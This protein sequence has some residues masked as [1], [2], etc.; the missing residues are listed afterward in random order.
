M[1]K[2]ILLIAFRNLRKHTFYSTINIAGLAIGV[3]ACLLIT[4]FIIDELSYDKYN[5]K[6]DRIYRINNEIKFG[7]NHMQL[8]TSAAPT[9]HTLIQDYPEVEAAVRFRSYGSYLVKAENSTEN[10]KENNVIWTDSTFFKIFSVKVLEGNPNT[11]LKEPA[12]IAISKRTAEKHFPNESALGKTMILDNKYNAKVTAVYENIPSTSHFHFDI[13]IAMVGDWPVAREAQSSAYLSNNFN[14]YLLLK[15][16]A[17]A[18]AFERKL[19]EFLIKY[20][21]PQIAQVLGD[22]FTL[23]KFRE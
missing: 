6:A 17:D 5:E 20:I 11:A 7:G 10:I 22:E 23:E 21:G 4:L 3:S 19:P 16:G 18:K 12:S 13:L 2:S 9:A 8:A 15:E 14:S 1:L